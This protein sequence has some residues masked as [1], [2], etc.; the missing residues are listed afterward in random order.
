[1]RGAVARLL[2]EAETTG[3][4]TAGSIDVVWSGLSGPPPGQ[5]YS[6]ALKRSAGVGSR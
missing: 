1:M 2:R 6:V 4:A 3:A 5:R